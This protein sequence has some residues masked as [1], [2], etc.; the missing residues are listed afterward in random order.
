MNNKGLQK[1]LILKKNTD[2]GYSDPDCSSNFP[3]LLFQLLRFI[4]TDKAEGAESGDSAANLLPLAD[5]Y[6][7]PRLKAIC[8]ESIC[9]DIDV[10]NAVH[11]LILGHLH[12]AK[13][14]KAVALEFVSTNLVSFILQSSLRNSNDPNTRVVWYSVGPK[15]SDSQL[16]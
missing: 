9:D 5:K 2:V 15:L 12:E 14:L 13:N 1:P 10:S 4:Y 8:E 7:L 16:F 3:F 6:N 11:S